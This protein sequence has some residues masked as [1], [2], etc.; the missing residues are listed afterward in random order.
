MPHQFLQPQLA[1]MAARACAR[2]AWY[3]KQ[4]DSIRGLREI[5]K[6]A[7]EIDSKLLL[8]EKGIVRTSTMGGSMTKAGIAKTNEDIDD[9][10]GY[11]SAAKSTATHTVWACP[12]PE[13]IKQ[14]LHPELAKAPLKYLLHCIQCGIAPPMNADGN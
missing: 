1:P 8:E 7:S 3:R 2:A 14:D 6:E 11:C 4:V 12:S 9:N 10:C 5:D 13:T